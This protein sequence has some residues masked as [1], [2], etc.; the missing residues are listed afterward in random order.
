MDDPTSEYDVLDK[1]DLLGCVNWEPEDQQ[2]VRKNL[3]EY[4]DVFAKDNLNLKITLKEG[5][6]PIKE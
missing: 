3:R 1:V 5:A 4:A 2:R 6:K